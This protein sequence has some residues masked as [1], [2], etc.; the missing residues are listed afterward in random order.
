MVFLLQRLEQGPVGTVAHQRGPVVV[1]LDRMMKVRTQDGEQAEIRQNL[2]LF[3]VVRLGFGHGRLEEP[4]QP[5]DH[6]VGTSELSDRCAIRR[7]DAIPR[8]PLLTVAQLPPVA[9]GPIVAD[10][11]P[12]CPH[13]CPGSFDS[14]ELS[15]QE[16]P[17]PPPGKEPG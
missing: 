13:S 12:A 5:T 11:Q 4:D 3:D 15:D 6:V 16:S 7:H 2:H 17:L 1:V 14:P 9:L 8:F 10:C